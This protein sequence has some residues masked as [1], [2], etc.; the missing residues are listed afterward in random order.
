VYISLI[1][2]ITAIQEKDLSRAEK[3][4]DYHLEQVKQR[5]IKASKLHD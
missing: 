1:L 3:A 5:F 2:I 4:L